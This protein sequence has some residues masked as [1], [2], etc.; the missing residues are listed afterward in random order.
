MQELGLLL[1]NNLSDEV[2]NFTLLHGW[3]IYDVLEQI[4]C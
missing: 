4:F 2:L 1:I 3:T